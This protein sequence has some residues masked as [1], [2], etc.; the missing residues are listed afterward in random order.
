MADQR[1]IDANRL[2]RVLE[3]NF[4]HTGGAAVLRQLIDAAPTVPA[5]VLPLE[6]G[7]WIS[8]KD[9]LPEDYGAEYIVVIHGAGAAT[10]LEFDGTS[11]TDFFGEAYKVDYWQPLPAPPEAAR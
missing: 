1:L 2:Q 5:T 6:A 10:V 4:G 7:I 9:R 3:K 8:V 11:W